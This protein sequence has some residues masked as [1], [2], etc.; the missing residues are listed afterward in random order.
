MSNVPKRSISE[1]AQALCDAYRGYA[2]AGRE[3]IRGPDCRVVR[4]HDAPDVYDA[5]FLEVGPDSEVES[6]L[7]FLDVEFAGRTHRTV[8]TDPFSP[9][10]FD[11]ELTLRNFLPDPT[12]Q[13]LLD[14]KS[15]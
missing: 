15:P 10:E 6:A 13:L 2:C 9:P 8:R 11:A 4:N 1:N 3:I 12:I 7:A 14:I 5:N